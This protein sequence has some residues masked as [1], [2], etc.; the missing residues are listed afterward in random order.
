MFFQGQKLREPGRECDGERAVPG[1]NRVHYQRGRGHHDQGTRLARLRVDGT[2]D[3][4]LDLD[5]D[6][7]VIPK[8]FKGLAEIVQIVF[9][10]LC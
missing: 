7:N 2:A 5:F 4:I 10:D 3:Q 9:S 8:N 1:E 6:L